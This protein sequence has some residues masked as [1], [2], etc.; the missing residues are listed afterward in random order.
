M[1]G[2]YMKKISEEKIDKYYK[3][4]Y[5]ILSSIALGSFIFIL[6]GLFY[7]LFDVNLD[8]LNSNELLIAN[9]VYY[10]FVVIISIYFYFINKKSSLDEFKKYIRYFLIGSSSMFV[11]FVMSFFEGFVLYVFGVNVNSMSIFSKT[12]YLISFEFLIIGIIALINNKTLSECI[13]NFKFKNIFSY[14][15]YYILAL[16]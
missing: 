8:V 16:V 4:S 14:F 7:L 12:I 11:Y 10:F 1:L 15:K 3:E 13:K 5:L 2:G 6:K 9:I